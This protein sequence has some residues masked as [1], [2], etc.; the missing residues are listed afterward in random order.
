MGCF[1]QVCCISGLPIT[2]GDRVR[3]FLLTENPYEDSLICSNA[4]LYFPRTYPLSATYNHYGS[5]EDYDPECPQ[6]VGLLEQFKR[7]L[8][9]VGVGDNQCHD[10]ATRKDMSFDE[11][12]TAVWERRILVNREFDSFKEQDASRLLDKLALLEI[13]DE[14]RNEELYKKTQESIC[15]LKERISE[16][17]TPES[18]DWLPT[19]EKI[20]RLLKEAGYVVND[21]E[22]TSSGPKTVIVD[23]RGKGWVRIRPGGFGN[24]APLQPI[25]NL[26][27]PH[28]SAMITAGTGRGA[29]TSEIQ[30]MPLPDEEGH[31]SFLQRE[32]KKP[33]K[34]YQGMILEDVWQGIIHF[35]GTYK[36]RRKEL[37]EEWDSYQAYEKEFDELKNSALT[38][39]DLT[40]AYERTVM[41][42]IRCFPMSPLRDLLPFSMSLEQHH[43]YIRQ[44]L[45][46]RTYTSDQM[47][48][49]LDN[50]A[51]MFS[52]LRVMYPL[53]YAWHP[54]FSF[55]PQSAPYDEHQDWHELLSIISAQLNKRHSYEED[56]DFEDEEEI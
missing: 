49:Y 22:P 44:S 30:V 15:K 55:G 43:K 39:E 11:V 29:F 16:K 51:G 34:V 36:K 26:L 48:D 42:D 28:F 52:V 27:S 18:P 3:Y 10:V 41:K 45:D 31:R 6:I 14:K 54:S 13:L 4:D 7:D 2:E 25:I 1:N 56:E 40:K 9:P 38:G 53:G 5:I 35:D 21:S 8:V 33:L 50:I 46:D 23:G 37:Q 24:E 12:L 17:E 47:A 19:V 32:N 20:S